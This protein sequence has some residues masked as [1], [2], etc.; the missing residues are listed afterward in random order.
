[1]KKQNLIILIMVFVIVISI[2]AQDE[3]IMQ[4]AS[5]VNDQAIT[6]YEIHVLADAYMK[7]MDRSFSRDSQE[8]QQLIASVLDNLINE[9]IVFQAAVDAGVRMP[10]NIL[11]RE[12]QRIKESSGARSEEEFIEM[13]RRENMTLGSFRESL[14][15]RNIV[16]I[17][18]RNKLKEP[19]ITEED[20]R[21]YYD[22]NKENYI[23]QERINISLISLEES[24]KAIDIYNRILEGDDFEALA[25]QYSVHSGTSSEGGYIGTVDFNNLNPAFVNELQGKEKGFVT[26]PFVF[27]N[28]FV[29]LRINETLPRSYQDF[30]EV[31]NDIMDKLYDK[32]IER[33][34]KNLVSDLRR[35]SLIE[36]PIPVYK[37]IMEKYGDDYEAEL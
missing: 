32:R 27:D 36:F 21:N 7:Q 19:N 37:E 1:M 10:E 18:I 23:R 11:D 9:L 28:N 6:D 30:E 16:Q 14:R 3:L 15:R 5:K 2:S 20:A 34:Y 13:L 25:R 4:I 12:L 31:K 29:I 33:N 24:S 35:S 17:Y 8:Y 22:K 26:R